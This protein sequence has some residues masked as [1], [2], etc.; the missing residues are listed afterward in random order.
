MLAIRMRTFAVSVSVEL[1][2]M[3]SGLNFQSQA[4]ILTPP[5]LEGTARRQ[6]LKVRRRAVHHMADDRRLH[7]SRVTAPVNKP[8]QSSERQAR[9]SLDQMSV[10]RVSGRN[11]ESGVV[12]AG[13]PAEG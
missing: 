13:I 6:G 4:A 2:F 9:E 8:L 5:Y 3:L 1:P 12:T 11:K 10:R 7:T